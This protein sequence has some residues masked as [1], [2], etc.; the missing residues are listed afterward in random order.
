MTKINIMMPFS[1]GH[2]KT[3]LIKHYEPMDITIH[4]I[5]F[6]SEVYTNFDREWVK[7]FF[8]PKSHPKPSTY[9][10]LYAVNYFLANHKFSDDD[11]YVITPDDD[12]YAPGVFNA[13]KK[14]NDNI[15]VISMDRGDQTRHRRYLYANKDNMKKE[16]VGGEQFF[17]K[18][19]I[20]KKIQFETNRCADGIMVEMLIKKYTFRYEPKLFVFFNYLNPKWWKPVL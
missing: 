6:E 12:I 11:Y 14:M 19:K 5:M 8:I 3:T 16:Y 13:I 9:A 20:Y 15:V 1:R 10:A 18:G 7:P 4:Q 2:L 17:I